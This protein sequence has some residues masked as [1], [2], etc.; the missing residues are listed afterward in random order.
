MNPI[1]FSDIRQMNLT[2]TVVI[3]DTPLVPDTASV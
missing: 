2:P 3:D 1:P